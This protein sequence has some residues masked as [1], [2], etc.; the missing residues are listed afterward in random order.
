MSS[1][2]DNAI[3]FV[4]LILGMALLLAVLVLAR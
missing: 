1:K 3:V 2:R 4:P